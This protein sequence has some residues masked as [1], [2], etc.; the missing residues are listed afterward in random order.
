MA[1][2]LF[3]Y[4]RAQDLGA[5]ITPEAMQQMLD[6]WRVWINDGLQN[7]WIVDSGDALT[8]EGRVV[9]PAK[10]VTDGPFVESK[11]I[12]GGYSVIEAKTIDAAAEL[13]HGCPVLLSGGAVE[14]RALAGYAMGK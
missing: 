7:G 5:T 8:Q 4:R 14:V 2:F 9:R 3:V 12:I 1:K 13:A 11:E 10:V 6:R